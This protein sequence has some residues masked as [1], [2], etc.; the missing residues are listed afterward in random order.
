MVMAIQ[1]NA[2]YA[3][4]LFQLLQHEPSA[5]DNDFVFDLVYPLLELFERLSWDT[6]DFTHN[7]GLSPVDLGD[8]AVDHD[9]CLGDLAGLG[10]L[11]GSPNG[12]RAVKGAGQGRMEVDAGDREGLVQGWRR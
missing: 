11:V 10:G 2:S 7:D 4:L 12:V 9:A 6:L 3:P 5:L 1:C 8:D